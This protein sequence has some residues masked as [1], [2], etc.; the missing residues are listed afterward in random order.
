WT[1]L[2][3]HA[4]A[5]PQAARQ[6][7]RGPKEGEPCPEGGS[8]FA[9]GTD[10]GKPLPQRRPFATMNPCRTCPKPHQRPKSRRPAEVGEQEGR[11]CTVLSEL[12]GR[13]SRYGP[14]PWLHL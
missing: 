12:S 1:R 11:T 5:E 3:L 14:W 9:F 7:A 10:H 2:Q 4:Q 13:K 6:H 8:R